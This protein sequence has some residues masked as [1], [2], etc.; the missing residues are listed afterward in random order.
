MRKHTY[1]CGAL[2]TIYSLFGSVVTDYRTRGYYDQ[3]LTT[4]VHSIEFRPPFP[5]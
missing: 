3:I 5:L 1:K 2:F 4:L